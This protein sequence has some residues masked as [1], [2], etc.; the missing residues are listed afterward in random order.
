M[1]F[2]SLND[3]LKFMKGTLKKEATSKTEFERNENEQ[4]SLLH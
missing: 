2:I 1:N 3:T 4:T